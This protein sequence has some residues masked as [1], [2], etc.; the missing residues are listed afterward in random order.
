MRPSTVSLI[1]PTYNHARHLHEAI[2]SAL[3]QTHPRVE[4]IVVDDG[5]TD[6]T[7]DILAKYHGRVTSFTQTNRGLAAARNAGLRIATGDYVA[8][9]DADDVLASNK[10]A[11]QAAVLKSDPRIGWTYCDVRMTNVVTGHD[12]VASERFHYR[13]RRL[14]GWLFAELVFANF[15]PAIAPM[16]RRSILEKAGGFDEAL[17]ALE[18]WDLW[19]RVSL[20]AEARYLPAVLATY[21]LQPEGMSQDRTRMD[22]NRFHVL[23]KAARAHQPAI[24]ALGGSGRQLLADVQNWFGYQAYARGDWAEAIRRL[25]ASLRAW[26]W[27]RR[28][29]VL[30]GMGYFRQWLTQ[31]PR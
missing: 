3:A 25:Q 10:L 19:L 23:E 20:V 15:I 14:N 18:D 9:L 31:S 22:A 6:E 17:T 24:A 16:I 26:P 4:V 27:Q 29:P 2:E 1:I 8:F 28:A 11:E 7:P 12:T 30:L 13:R 5:S 21:R